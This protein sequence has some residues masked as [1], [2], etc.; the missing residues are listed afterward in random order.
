MNR[1]LH[2]WGGIVVFCCCFVTLKLLSIVDCLRH[3]FLCWRSHP[4]VWI[5]PWCSLGH[6]WEP[7]GLGT[8]TEDK[9]HTSLSSAQDRQCVWYNV[10]LLRQKQEK[11]Q[12]LYNQTNEA[13]I[14]HR[15]AS[16]ILSVP[17]FDLLLI[18]LTYYLQK[19]STGIIVHQR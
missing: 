9:I 7:L 3:Y 18:L 6:S 12:Q 2:F 4:A 1:G 10:S 19:T 8:N 16:K 5:A 15:S 17:N 14:W 13:R 11:K